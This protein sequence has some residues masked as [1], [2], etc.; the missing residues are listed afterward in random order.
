MSRFKVG[1]HEGVKWVRVVAGWGKLNIKVFLYLVDGVLV[2][3]G[4][5][6][7]SSI[8]LPYFRQEKIETVLL[9]HYHEDHS[10][11]APYLAGRGI[12]VYINP[13]SLERC[14]ERTRLPFYRNIFWGNRVAFSPYPLDKKLTAGGLAWEP[15]PTPG[16]VFDHQAIYLPEKGILFTGDLFVTTRPKIILNTES[17]PRIMEDIKTVLQYDFTTVFCSHAGIVHR[18]REVLQKKLEY[19]QEIEEEVQHLYSQGRSVSEITRKLFPGKVP[20]EYISCREWSP[21][22]IV[23]SLVTGK[24]TVENPRPRT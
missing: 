21:G 22:H 20:L 18:G 14:R 2:D 1:E 8:L 23:K 16:H 7:L 3:T 4:P 19:L 13:V 9:T 11:N 5:T 17:T 6:R 10:G 24:S 12:P 15:V